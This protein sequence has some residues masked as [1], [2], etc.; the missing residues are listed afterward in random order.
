MKFIKKIL[1]PAWNSKYIFFLRM[2]YFDLSEK[3]T[4]YR[5][6][7]NRF[8]RNTGYKLDLKNPNSFSSHLVWKKIYDRNPILPILSDK[9]RV[10]EYLRDFL[11]EKESNEILIPLLYSGEDP[12]K[13]PFDNLKG[14]YII[15]ANHNSGPNF[16]V[17]NGQV[18]D[19]QKIISS[20]KEQL[21][22]PYAV[23][24]HEW[25]Y[26]KI[27][28]RMIIVE[29]LLRDEEGKI[30]R[31]Y[32]FHMINGKCAF[33][34]VDFDRFID[35]SRTLYDENW[36]FIHTTLK[37]K[38]GPDVSKPKNFEKML[39]FAKKLS[40]GFDYIRIDLYDVGQK[41]YFGEMTHYPGS[42]V[43]KFTPIS[44]D[45]ELNKYWENDR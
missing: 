29:R 34:Q 37:F 22:F 3:I 27:K 36:K 18:P 11:G 32:K 30:P 28:K 5:E 2:W 39:Y 19:K 26:R 4:C 23:F 33:V 16:I 17:E 13:I 31:D 40:K 21:K 20:L 9:Y 44:F 12:N 1:K 35:H 41:V 24:K 7:K 43:E 10:R 38:Q 15:K 42:G 25:A 45:F 14:E 8:L 6:E